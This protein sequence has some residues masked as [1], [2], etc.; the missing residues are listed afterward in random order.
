MNRKE[1]FLRAGKNFTYHNINDVTNGAG[2][3]IPLTYLHQISQ[4]FGMNLGFI[5]LK[6]SREDGGHSEVFDSHPICT[7][8]NLETGQTGL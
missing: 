8:Q 1:F 4:I 5:H 3:R 6:D 7:N 2:G